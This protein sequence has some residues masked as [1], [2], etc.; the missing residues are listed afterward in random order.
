MGE[1][2][3]FSG[4]DER[5]AVGWSVFT[6]SVIKRASKSVHITP[7]ASMGLPQGSNT[8]TLSRFLVPYLTGFKGHAI[9]ADACDMIMMTDVA[10]LDAMFDSR[11]AVQVVKHPDYQCQHARK[12]VGTEMECEQ[13]NYARKNWA[14]LAIM[15]CAHSAWFAMTPKMISMAEPLDLLQ[16]KFFKDSEIGELPNEWNV[17]VD[18]GQDREGAKLLHFTNGLPTFKHYRNQ[19]GSA[20]W[21]AEF[22]SMT[23][24]MQHG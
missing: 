23:K 2:N 8:F 6:H 9:F 10:E 16:F 19:R 11:Y 24:A 13:T 1:I 4:Y 7:L 3:L 12:Y 5:E 21:F 20:D 22:D 17:L 18:E 15:N 14:S